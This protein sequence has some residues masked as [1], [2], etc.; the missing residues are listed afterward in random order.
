MREEVEEPGLL[1]LGGY[2]PLADFCSYG[3]AAPGRTGRCMCRCDG[4]TTRRPP[5]M[6][7]TIPARSACALDGAYAQKLLRRWLDYHAAIG[8]AHFV[9]YDR[10]GSLQPFVDSYEKPANLTLAYHWNW[11]QHYLTR[12]HHAVQQGRGNRGLPSHAAPDAAAAAHCILSTL[13]NMHLG[14]TFGKNKNIWLPAPKGAQI[15]A[16][17]QVTIQVE[18]V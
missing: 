13:Q 1:L 7:A 15:L 6:A 3:R 16:T 17:K 12:A 18:A 8:V 9:L 2:F 10:D 14:G 11:S 4:H 5:P